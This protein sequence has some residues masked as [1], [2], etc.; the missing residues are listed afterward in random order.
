M[1]SPTSSVSSGRGATAMRAEGAMLEIDESMQSHLEAFVA[2]CLTQATIKD[3]PTW[4]VRRCVPIRVRKFANLT[5]YSPRR[6]SSLRYDSSSTLSLSTT[7]SES[8]NPS[9]PYFRPHLNRNPGRKGT[10]TRSGKE[11]PSSWIVPPSP[12]RP[13]RIISPLVVAWQQIETLHILRM[14]RR[15]TRLSPS[16][17]E[18]RRPTPSCRSII[19]RSRSRSCR[20]PNSRTRLRH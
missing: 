1:E 17:L 4:S 12:Q 18:N 2:Q 13:I 14:N 9:S 8:Q 19:S 11:T 15:T 16:R 5:T 20:C 3:V 10:P 6:F 7:S